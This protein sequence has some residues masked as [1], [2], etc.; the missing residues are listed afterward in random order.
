MALAHRPDVV[1]LDLGLPGCLDGYEIARQ[2]RACPQTATSLLVAVTGFGQDTDRQRAAEVGFDHFLMKPSD[3]Q[4]LQNLLD[5]HAGFTP[6]GEMPAPRRG[7]TQ[8]AGELPLGP[9]GGPLA[10]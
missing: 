3:P 2:L 5:R 8:D 9:D 6:A 1:I 7:S 10:V 4:Q